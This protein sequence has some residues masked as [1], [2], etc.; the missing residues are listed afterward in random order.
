MGLV[1]GRLAPLLEQGVV[2]VDELGLQKVHVVLLHVPPRAFGDI[3]VRQAGD[4]P[5]LD[6]V[7]AGDQRGARVDG[8]RAPVHLP[9]GESHGAVGGQEPA[10]VGVQR[11]GHLELLP[12]E[13]LVRQPRPLLEHQDAMPLFHERDEAHGGRPS[14]RSR[15]DDH[16]VVAPLDHASSPVPSPAVIRRRASQPP[17]SAR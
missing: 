2:L 9:E 3:G 4:V 5:G 10:G 13:L 1:A 16:D 15:A 11:L 14:A 17:G 8:G 12:G 7:R 6:D